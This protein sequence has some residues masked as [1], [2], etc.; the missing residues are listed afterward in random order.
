[1]VVSVNIILNN[2]AL[3]WC[4]FFL[5]VFNFNG[6]IIENVKSAISIFDKIWYLMA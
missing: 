3:T 2:V 5:K 4:Y 1:M 6:F